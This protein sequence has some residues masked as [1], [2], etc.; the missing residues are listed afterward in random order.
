MAYTREGRAVP[1]I[2]PEH[3]DDDDDAI[4]GDST[5]I[6]HFAFVKRE[7][8]ILAGG[9]RKNRMCILRNCEIR[10]ELEIV[11]IFENDNTIARCKSST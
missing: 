9:S 2:W 10:R 3:V 1:I 4:P 5:P 7:E 6:C 11:E 8:K